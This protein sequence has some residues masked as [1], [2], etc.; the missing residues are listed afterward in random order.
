[1]I[2]MINAQNKTNSFIYS[3]FKGYVN[4]WASDVYNCFISTQFTL[5]KFIPQFVYLNR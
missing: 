3:N 5:N 4:K 2:N 1:M